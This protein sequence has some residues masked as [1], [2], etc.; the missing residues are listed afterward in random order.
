MRVNTKIT[1]VCYYQ[2][3]NIS[4]THEA[5][6]RDVKQIPTESIEHGSEI[7][8]ASF[9]EVPHDNSG[10]TT[11]YSFK[12]EDTRL[13]KFYAITRIDENSKMKIENRFDDSNFTDDSLSYYKRNILA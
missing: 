13:K 4:R 3:E 12:A 10:Q 5:E 2:P 11:D 1:P 6:L 8:D 7:T 9:T